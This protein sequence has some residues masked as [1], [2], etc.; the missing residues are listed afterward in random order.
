MKNNFVRTK[1]VRNE[2]FFLHYLLSI[3]HYYSCW[4]CYVIFC[5][6]E[7]PQISQIVSNLNTVNQAQLIRLIC[8]KKLSNFIL[9]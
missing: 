5:F 4:L 6:N 7:K 3:L 2:I 9:N 1:I 8:L